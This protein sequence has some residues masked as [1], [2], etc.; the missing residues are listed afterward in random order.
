[1][2][3]PGSKNAPEVRA[4]EKIDP[5][6]GVARVPDG[7]RITIFRAVPEPGLV[8]TEGGVVLAQLGTGSDD[9]A[10]ELAELAR[11]VEVALRRPRRVVLSQHAGPLSS[12]C[13]PSDPPVT[14]VPALV[15]WIFHSGGVE[16]SAGRLEA[17][18]ECLRSASSHATP[19]PSSVAYFVDRVSVHLP[20]LAELLAGAGI[21]SRHT[22]QDGAV[23]AEVH[24]PEGVIIS[25]LCGS[26]VVTGGTAGGRGETSA[27]ALD[28]APRL[29]R[30]VLAAIDDDSDNAWRA[31]TDELLRREWPLLL[32]GDSA[33]RVSQRRWG[34]SE[35][36]L[37]AYPDVRSFAFAVEDLRPPGP[38]AM[39]AMRPR[40]LF[41]WASQLGSAIALNAYR[42]RARPQYLML[43]AR[44]VSAL[45]RGESG[46]R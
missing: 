6:V 29:Q 33:G 11:N 8:A 37:A 43:D 15:V 3:P 2:P 19:P 10:M 21:H 1:M 30:L 5:P 39:A 27:S 18:V 31:L 7:H 14:V 41:A 36:A 22:E 23:L 34:G 20:A 25:A 26:E 32:I 16:A 44:R 35:A 24:R 40:A 12:L 28:R 45:A 38:V 42:D 17:V 46:G 13:T 9:A 4:R